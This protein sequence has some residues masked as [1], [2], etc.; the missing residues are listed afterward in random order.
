MAILCTSFESTGDVCDLVLRVQAY[1]AKRTMGLLVAVSRRVYI[2][3]TRLAYS[4]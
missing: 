1:A 4:L 3:E 2:F